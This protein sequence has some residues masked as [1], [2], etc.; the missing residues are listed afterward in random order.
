M[1]LNFQN[2]FFVSLREEKKVFMM[3]E[4]KTIMFLGKR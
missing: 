3:M 1:D 4:M 2:L